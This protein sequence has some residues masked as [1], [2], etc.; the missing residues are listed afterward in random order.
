[1]AHELT[2]GHS[3]IPS[4]AFSTAPGDEPGWRRSQATDVRIFSPLINFNSRT[5]DESVKWLRDFCGSLSCTVMHSPAIL[6]VNA[7]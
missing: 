6:S 1:M 4:R 3:E 7:S 5:W 2:A